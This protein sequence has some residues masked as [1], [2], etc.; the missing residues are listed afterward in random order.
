MYIAVSDTSSFIG[1]GLGALAA[2]LIAK[3]F[4]DWRCVLGGWTFNI[5]HAIF[6]VSAILRFIAVPLFLKGVK[7]P[8]NLRPRTAE[9]L[10]RI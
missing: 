9:S 1:N 2:G 10:A 8:A 4:A 6:L 7:D 5:F 3:A